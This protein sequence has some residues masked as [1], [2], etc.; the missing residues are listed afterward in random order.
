MSAP[1]PA[2]AFLASLLGDPADPVNPFGWP[3]ALRRESA[4]EPPEEARERLAS[5]GFDE[6]LIP[7]HWPTGGRL[8]DLARPFALARG[9]AG[10]DAALTPP[11][12][13]KLGTLALGELAGTPRQKAILSGV[14]RGGGLALAFA[15]P[16]RPLAEIR[17][18]ASEEASFWRL[19]GR[20][21]LAPGAAGALG[22]AAL[23]R[24]P[25]PETAGVS[26]FL[27]PREGQS[28]RVKIGPRR[29]LL[30]LSGM[31]FAEIR[32]DAAEA[33][34]RIGAAGEGLDLARRVLA[35]AK[36]FNLATLFGPMETALGLA[37]RLENAQNAAGRAP[38]RALLSEALA[39]FW[40]LEAFAEAG[41]R[42]F[43][44]WPVQAGLWADAL[45]ARA[46]EAV[47]PIFSAAAA[48]LGARGALA[49]D[50]AGALFGK[51]RRDAEAARFLDPEGPQALAGL[52]AHLTP[53]G[54]ASGAMDPQACWTKL[55]ESFGGAGPAEGRW[56]SLALRPVAGD[57]LSESASALIAAA[58]EDPRLG[59]E[60]RA[61]L[62]GAL[63]KSMGDFAALNQA[64]AALSK[65]HG[66]AYALSP[67]FHDAGAAF[68]RHLALTGAAAWWLARGQDPR[69]FFQSGEALALAAA[70]LSGAPAP[71]RRKLREGVWA[72]WRAEAEAARA[73]A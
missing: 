67:E 66:S 62:I 7:A 31:D 42:A 33:P 13:V 40:A 59:A 48:S 54:A 14:A 52:A 35:L 26:I 36:S 16:G 57:A 50:P 63:R 61:T 39:A 22:V 21:G 30:G 4:G 9:L 44:A 60:P 51:L 29:R 23:A 53:L 25:G 12:A 38:E 27:A 46:F 2:S 41:L 58:Q 73:V 68:A 64:H 20:K 11:L 1:P 10:R 43:G 32:F 3:Q 28:A 45:Q 56:S 15:E 34:E 70:Q 69:P 47:G 65:A 8:T 49:D 72:I 71:Q 24:E 17:A 19:S 18:A 55:R 37:A 6:E 5:S